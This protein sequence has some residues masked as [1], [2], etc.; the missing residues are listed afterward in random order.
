MK[1]LKAFITPFET[2]QRSVKK[3]K[4]TKATFFSLPGIGTG[5]A[6]VINLLHAIDLFLYPMKASHETRGFLKFSGSI[7]KGP[8]IN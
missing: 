6:K 1:A 8:V 2:P 5:R 4:K 7:E 3:N